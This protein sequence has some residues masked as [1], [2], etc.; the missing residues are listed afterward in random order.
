MTAYSIRTMTLSDYD[1]CFELWNIKGDAVSRADSTRETFY[2]ILTRNPETCF[3][4]V[5]GNKIIGTIAAEF[6]GDGAY[7][8]H[9]C[10]S[11]EFRRQGIATALVDTVE[12][13]LAEFGVRKSRILVFTNNETAKF[14]WNS[15]GYAA[16]DE[17]VF[18]DRKL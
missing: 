12:G 14:F 10:V 11:P 16:R 7:I 9:L 2:K 8:S 3:V 5:A 15:R 13:K 6:G 4:A 17:V 1:E 18:M